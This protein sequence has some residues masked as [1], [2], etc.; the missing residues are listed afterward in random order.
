MKIRTKKDVQE[1]DEKIKT[2]LGID[3]SEYKNEDVAENFAELLM[4][5]SYMVSWVIRPIIFSFIL[6]II[7]FYT[8]NLVHVEY[9]L[10]A[11][12]G[13]LFFMLAG[14]AFGFLLLMFK[15]KKDIWS[16]ADY[17]LD[18]LKLSVEDLSSVNNQITEENKKDV[19][20]LLFKGIIHIVT[21]PM[22]S[23]SVAKKIPVLGNLAGGIIRRVL[24]AISDKLEFEEDNIDDFAE[25]TTEGDSK[26]L[27]SYIFTITKVSEGL[28][29]F[30]NFTFKVV[31]FPI[32]IFALFSFVLLFLFLYLIH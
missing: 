25:E 21:I 19:L 1:L 26:I 14:V 23:Q 20:S 11:L 27:S 28:E 18:I 15:M 7:G 17:S 8:L 10:Y 2:E 12:L 31:R 9:L 5:P 22:L 29:K 24:V 6:Y 4:L 30:V 3:V 13:F 32:I 16:I